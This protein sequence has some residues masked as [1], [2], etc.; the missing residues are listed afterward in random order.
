MV[1]NV[2]ATQL[3]ERTV[4]RNA[5]ERQEVTLFLLPFHIVF[6]RI[7]DTS[8]LFSLFPLIDCL[9]TCRNRLSAPLGRGLI[10]RTRTLDA[11]EA[12][13]NRRIRY[14]SRSNFIT[15]T[16]VMA[17]SGADISSHEMSFLSSASWTTTLLSFSSRP[18]AA[19]DGSDSTHL[20]EA[21]GLTTSEGVLMTHL[22]VWLLVF[23][24]GVFFGL[25]V[26]AKCYRRAGLAVDDALLAAAWVSDL[27][28]YDF[29]FRSRPR[30][31]LN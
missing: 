24:S 18:V 5:T 1:P 8:S 22:V 28:V 9:Y 21:R 3:S 10:G 27:P 14:L 29:L 23:V 30:S 6:L 4:G 31:M 25:R 16:S 12:S 26:F 17:P 15:Y 20:L 13:G 2:P 19:T 11:F 7:L